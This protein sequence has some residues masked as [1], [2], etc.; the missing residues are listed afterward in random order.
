MAISSVHRYLVRSMF[1]NKVLPAKGALLEIGEANWYGVVDTDELLADINKY[2]ADAARRTEL[3]KRLHAL[4]LSDVND[5][6]AAVKIFYEVFFSPDNM[7]AVDLQGT[8]TALRLDL[9]VPISLDRRFGVVINH[10]TA[11]HIFNIAQVFA[12][13]H[14]YTLPGG[15]MIHES[16]FTGWIE[17]G[18]Y[19]LQPTLFFDLAAANHYGLLGMFIEDLTANTLTQ[20][21]SRE[22]VYELATAKAIPENT[23]LFVVFAKSD[24]DR[25]F[26]TPMQGYYADTLSEAG[27]RAWTELR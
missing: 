13:M 19:N 18:F 20:I 22:S 16:P 17:H 6:F 2:V 3:T 24:T 27:R 7:Q 8:T 25:A 9:N 21:N 14:H 11:E 12:T 10:G 23:M 4:D 15:L 26:K 1:E 5:N